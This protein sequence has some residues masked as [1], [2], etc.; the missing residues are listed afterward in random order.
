MVLLINK[1]QT[2]VKVRCAKSILEIGLMLIIFMID[3]DSNIDIVSYKDYVFY[4]MGLSLYTIF[5]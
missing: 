3:I 2:M 4:Y 5:F 1:Y